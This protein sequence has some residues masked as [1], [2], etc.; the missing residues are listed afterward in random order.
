MREDELPPHLSGI[1]MLAAIPAGPDR[2]D[3]LAEAIDKALEVAWWRGYHTAHRQAA[4]KP[5][6]AFRT[7][8]GCPFC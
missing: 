6:W 8:R 5:K 7:G 3:R 1:E 4:T 2:N